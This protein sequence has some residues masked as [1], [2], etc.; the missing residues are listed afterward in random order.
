[1]LRFVTEL[2]GSVFNEVLFCIKS[3]FFTFILERLLLG[4]NVELWL[5]KPMFVKYYAIYLKDKSC[6][7]LI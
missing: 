6:P 7:D 2:V 3:I 1:L 4:V 5:D